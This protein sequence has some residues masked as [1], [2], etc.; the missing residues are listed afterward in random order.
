MKARIRQVLLKTSLLIAHFSKKI[1]ENI[2][3]DFFMKNQLQTDAFV[4]FVISLSG[5]LSTSS[6]STVNWRRLL[7]EGFH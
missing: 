2:F 6:L 1:R 5:V 7:Q 4:A 3:M